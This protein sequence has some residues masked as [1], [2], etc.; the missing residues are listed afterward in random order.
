MKVKKK[1]KHK[2]KWKVCDEIWSQVV[3]QRAEYESEYSGKPYDKENGIY[4][5]AHHLIG[6]PNYRMRY[7]LLNGFCLTL[8]EHKWIAHH[9]GRVAAF[10]EVVKSVRGDDIFEILDEMYRLSKT[11]KTDL[12]LIKLYLEGELK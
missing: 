9:E 11:G 4:L 8:G 5:C 3:R 7:E 2:S 1:I 12:T 10:K 6:K